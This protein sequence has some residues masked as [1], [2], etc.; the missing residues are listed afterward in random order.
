[1]TIGLKIDKLY[2]E[3]KKQASKAMDK[4]EATKPRAE[5]QSKVGRN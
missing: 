2:T 5:N 4:P 1:M 3:L